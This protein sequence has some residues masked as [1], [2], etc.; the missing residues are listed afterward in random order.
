MIAEVECLLNIIIR[1]PS[2]MR[3]TAVLHASGKG[4]VLGQSLSISLGSGWGLAV[5]SGGA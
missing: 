3:R 1:L 4:F 2:P 5:H